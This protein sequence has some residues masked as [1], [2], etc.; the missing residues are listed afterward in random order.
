MMRDRIF[1]LALFASSLVFM[2]PTPE[3]ALPLQYDLHQCLPQEGELGEWKRDGAPQ[4]F[5][6]EDLYL[7]INGG[8][9]IYHEYGFRQVIIQDYLNKNGKSISLEIF[10]M[11]SPESAYGIYTFKTSSEGKEITLGSQAQLADYYLN[12]W[13]GNFLITLTGFDEN[14]ETIRGLLVI[15]R[16]VEAK[17]EFKGKRPPLVA[18]FPEKGLI[19]PSIKYIKGNL[20]LYNSYQFF[21]KDIFAF[22]EGAIGDYRAGHSVFMLKYKSHDGCQKRFDEV[23]KGF[24][25]SPRYKEFKAL[26]E[27]LFRVRDSK[28]KFVFVT[29]FKEYILVTI[30]T[31][32]LERA[33]EIFNDIQENI[34]ANKK[35]KNKGASLAATSLWS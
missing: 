4:E 23:R 29:S 13:K 14:E 26:D 27:N 19:K 17:I 31:D 5:R 35:G 11:T 7:Y 24:R 21:T 20:A 18:L 25:E 33:E 1:L 16:A 3:K 32:G 6:G 2:G 15:A 34:K 9:E 8:A 12:F 22:K 10:E 30:D 28:G